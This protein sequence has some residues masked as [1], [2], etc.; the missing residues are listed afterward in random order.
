MRGFIRH[1]RIQAWDFTGSR[2]TALNWA[3]LPG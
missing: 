2:P 3:I 1:E